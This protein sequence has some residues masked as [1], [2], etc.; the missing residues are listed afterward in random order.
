MG[1]ALACATVRRKCCSSSRGRRYIDHGGKHHEP[2]DANALR[3]ARVCR[4]T[5]SG[6]LRHSGNEWHPAAYGFNG[7]RQDG[8]FFLGTERV[9]LTH[10]SEE[11][12]AVNAVAHQRRL[13][14]RGRREVNM[15]GGIKL[16]GGGGKHTGPWA[17]HYGHDVL[18]RFAVV[19][20]PIDRIR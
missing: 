15:S 10:G 1:R 8:A 4:G 6:E 12:E 5:C 14:D 11:H 17:P 2:V 18:T 19:D 7:A 3:I 16:S 9:I 13:H 20:G